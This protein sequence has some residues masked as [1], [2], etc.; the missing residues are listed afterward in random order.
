MISNR[1]SVGAIL[2]VS[3]GA[4]I[5]SILPPFSDLIA[6][7]ANNMWPYPGPDVHFDYFMGAFMG[8]LCGAVLFLAPF[9]PTIRPTLLACWAVKL[10]AALVLVPVY[11]YAYG[12]DIDGYFWFDEMPPG[13]WESFQG[14]GTLNVRMLAWGLFKIIGP[15]F[16]GGKV[17]FSFIGFLG[18][19]L[20]YRGA[21]SLTKS[22]RPLLLA[23]LSLTPTSLFWA[24]TLGK[25]PIVLFGVGLYCYGGFHW[26]EG[27]RWRH[28]LAVLAG[29]TLASLIRPFFLPIM[30]VP[31][32]VAFLFQSRRPIIRIFSLP[33]VV[34]GIN[35][36]ITS[37][38]TSMN[39][40]SFDSFVRY[41]A[42]VAA[43][44]HGGSSF[45]LPVIDTPLKLLLVAPLA[46]FTALFRPTLL[47]AHNFFALGAAIDNTILL[48]M[49]FYA[50]ARSR[51]RELLQ[52][53]LLW[54][55]WFIIMWSFM[56]GVGVGNLGAMSRFKVQVLPIFIVLLVYLARKRSAVLKIT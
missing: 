24:T 55:S 11:E 41:Q 48:V 40:E 8:L 26:L 18:T 43:G 7:A 5:A 22:E 13:E 3:V 56:Y 1:Q 29:A 4:M 36:S 54:M 38:K 31:L 45:V 21:T 6:L 49:F 53:E 2:A 9:P 20:A 30:G 10:A 46:I 34:W 50:I 51:V 39:I 16:H 44:W 14:A 35:F 12:L 17:L 33:V 47:E 28:L 27:F 15:S 52:P 19:Y 23:L 25:D 37:F 42:G 32:T